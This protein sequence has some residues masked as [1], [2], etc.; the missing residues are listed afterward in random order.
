MG[1]DRYHLV[2]PRKIAYN[3]ILFDISVACDV[4]PSIIKASITSDYGE[5]VVIFE[6]NVSSIQKALRMLK[7]SGVRVEKL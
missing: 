3:S 1:R 7:D 5:I 2:Y 6:G 4:S